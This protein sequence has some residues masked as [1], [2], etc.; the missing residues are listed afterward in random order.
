MTDDIEPEIAP[1]SPL[2]AGSALLHS[3]VFVGHSG[4]NSFGEFRAHQNLRRS[5]AG[6]M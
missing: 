3:N 2:A 1:L 4:P 6:V 5:L